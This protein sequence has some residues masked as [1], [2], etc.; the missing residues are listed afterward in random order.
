MSVT[1]DTN[2]SL[3]IFDKLS[4]YK[5]LEV[6]VTK[7]WQLKTTILS[8]VIDALGMI[9][10]TIPNHVSQIPGASSLTE[11]QKITLMGISTVLLGKISIFLIWIK[12]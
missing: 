10:K 2:V 4:K 5:D 11:L 9:A 12:G 3:K 7:M 6:E 1:S 8:E